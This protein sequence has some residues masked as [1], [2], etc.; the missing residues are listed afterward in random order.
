MS[1]Q[2]ALLN[3]ETL[4][5]VYQVHPSI[6][7]RVTSLFTHDDLTPSREDVAQVLALHSKHGMGLDLPRAYTVFLLLRSA[8]TFGMQATRLTTPAKVTL[9]LELGRQVIK[10]NLTEEGSD[11]MTCIQDLMDNPHL[12][13][14]TPAEPTHPDDS[15]HSWMEIDTSTET[16]QGPG[17]P[18]QPS[19]ETEQ[20]ASPSDSNSP[21]AHTTAHHPAPQD[22]QTGHPVDAT[23]TLDFTAFPQAQ[24]LG[25]DTEDPADPAPK[26]TPALAAHSAFHKN[27]TPHQPAPDTTA[28]QTL[29]GQAIPFT[30]ASSDTGN[31][32]SPIH[33][34]NQVH[35]P[36]SEVLAIPQVTQVITAAA[37]EPIPAFAAP[38]AWLQENR[39]ASPEEVAEYVAREQ[40]IDS[41]MI[42]LEALQPF[43][44]Y[45]ANLEEYYRANPDMKAEGD[46]DRV[47]A[48]GRAAQEIQLTLKGLGDDHYDLLGPEAQ[49]IV[50]AASRL[51]S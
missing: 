50:D 17:A 13:Q 8:T 48:A 40:T 26:S 11:L 9:A 7:G 16:A 14:V 21:A 33:Q 51:T 31:H 46:F 24:A 42:C 41:V 43:R 28:D 15:Q 35:T 23:T 44:T 2:P 18:A 27:T 5:T 36:E 38:P 22:V 30:A 34:S 20:P 49:V 32:T 6:I 29:P 12:E 4:A 39:N 47:L 37:G 10:A 3:P 1:Q 45:M 25:T 19:S